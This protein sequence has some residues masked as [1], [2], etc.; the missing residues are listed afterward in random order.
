MNQDLD[1]YFLMTLKASIATYNVNENIPS[2]GQNS[3][4]LIGAV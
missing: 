1:Y 2:S 3:T 4:H